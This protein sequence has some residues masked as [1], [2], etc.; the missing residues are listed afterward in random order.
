MVN[1]LL[2]ELQTDCYDIHCMVHG[3]DEIPGPR[4]AWRRCLE[5]GH[6]VQSAEELVRRYQ[7]EHH[8][9]LGVSLAP[10][11][12]TWLDKLREWWRVKTITVDKIYFCQECLHDW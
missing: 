6:L 11:K 5:C 7:E 10:G 2:H 12:M 8:N 1:E 9:L 3:V 4:G